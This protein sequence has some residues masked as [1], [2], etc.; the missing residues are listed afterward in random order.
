MFS[1]ICVCVICKTFLIKMLFFFGL[2]NECKAFS[3]NRER[4][5]ASITSGNDPPF[6][7]WI[8]QILPQNKICIS[9]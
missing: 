8:N 6:V 4:Q 5:V 9:A 7:V 3:T 1:S 2:N